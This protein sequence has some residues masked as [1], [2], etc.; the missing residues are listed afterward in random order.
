M[1]YRYAKY[2]GYDTSTSDKW[3]NF[4]D[5]HKVT[6]FAQTAMA[7]AVKNGMITGDQGK[8]NPQTN[9]SRAVAATLIQRFLTE[10]AGA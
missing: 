5:D 10:V 8:L 7:W 9:V 1:F 2:K 4:P 3:K 6:K